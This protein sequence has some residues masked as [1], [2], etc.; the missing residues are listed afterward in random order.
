MIESRVMYKFGLADE[1]TQLGRLY[2]SD[3]KPAYYH[4]YSVLGGWDIERFT[5]ILEYARKHKLEVRAW[6]LELSGFTLIVVKDYDTSE[7]SGYDLYK[8]MAGKY[9]GYGM[10]SKYEFETWGIPLYLGEDAKISDVEAGLKLMRAEN[11][12]VIVAHMV[13]LID[14]D[15]PCEKCNKRFQCFTEKQGCGGIEVITESQELV[16]VQVLK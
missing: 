1:N 9:E 6:K 11:S 10:S 14:N 16:K 8:K 15:L 3:N 5:P 4:A 2:P 7:D 12:G 13:F